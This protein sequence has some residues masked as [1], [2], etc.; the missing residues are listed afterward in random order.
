MVEVSPRLIDQRVCNRIIELVQGL[1]GGDSYVESVGAAEWIN[2]FFDWFPLEDQQSV[3]NSAMTADELQAVSALRE[4]MVQASSQTSRMI[5]DEQLQ[6]TGWPD[7]I[8]PHAERLL[9]LMQRRG[10][11]S[12]DV[13]DTE[14]LSPIP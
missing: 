6:A 4:M 11:F 9:K 2:S 7:R 13:E 5:T 8:R 12:E 3:T 10:R 14:P 1:C